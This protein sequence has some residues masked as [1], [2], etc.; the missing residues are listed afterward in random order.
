MPG[1]TNDE[2]RATLRR[3][4]A[5]WGLRH[6]E[7]DAAYFAWQREVF[8][9]QELAALHSRIE[10]KRLTTD[11]P[12]A[13][14]AFYDLTAQ[15]RTVP[16]LYSQRYDYYL[17]VGSRVVHH[18]G[19][20]PSI[21]D[22][23]CGIGILTTFYAQQWPGC[24]VLGVDR[25]PASIDLA[26][27]RALELGLTDLRFECLDLDRQDLSGPFDLI[28]AT[29][30]LLQAE[31]EPG[32]P[33]R[34]WRTFERSSDTQAQQRFEQRTG[35]GARLDRLRAMLTPQ[36]RVIVFEKARQ[37]ARLVP[38]QRALAARGFRL[39]VP[40]EPVRY[41][42]VEEVTDD[43]PLYVLGVAPQHQA[44]PWDESPEPDGAR[45]LD[46]EALRPVE[47]HGEQP[48]YENH[49]S[50][51]QQ[52]WKALPD[53]Q[54]SEEVTSEGPDGRQLHVERGRAGEFLYLYCANT[55]D[56]R[57]LV[58]IEPAR[59]AVLETY[60]REIIRDMAGAEKGRS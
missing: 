6:I 50:S 2:I 57:Q 54:V 15:P 37:L 45:S 43:G 30:T 13:E 56:Q 25:S 28:I 10:A 22:V 26:H 53:K 36:G 39:L 19:G 14:I 8:T 9:P 3:H 52:A 49:E 29:H 60:Y 21:L 38:F 18:I 33:S 58:V 16:A 32:L 34:D 20:A 7:S 40:P 11:G 23:G 46:I 51:A 41:R 55:F 47:S 5:W 42:S 17:Q 4:L 1:D 44:L 35:L 27:R 59:A 12:A 31:Q 24:R 48:L